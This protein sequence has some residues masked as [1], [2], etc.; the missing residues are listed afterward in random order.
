MAK[1]ADFRQ[2]SPRAVEATKA[3]ICLMELADTVGCAAPVA[4]HLEAALLVM[5]AAEDRAAKRERRP[6]LQIVGGKTH[7]I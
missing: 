6:A 7:A 5:K 4:R 3:V 1:T 2:F